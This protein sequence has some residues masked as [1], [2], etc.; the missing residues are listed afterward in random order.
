[1]VNFWLYLIISD[2]QKDKIEKGQKEFLGKLRYLKNMGIGDP[3]IDMFIAVIQGD[4]VL[5][6]SALERGANPNITD[7]ELY[8]ALRKTA[9]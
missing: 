9:V 2:G 5:L 7:A 3:E 8:R 6:T 4:E 1:M